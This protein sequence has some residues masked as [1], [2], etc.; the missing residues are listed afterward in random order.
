MLNE[1][2]WHKRQRIREYLLDV[3][4]ELPVGRPIPV[5]RQLCVDLGVSRPTLRS[6]VDDLVRDGRLVREHGRGVF[7][8]QAK[9]AQ[10]LGHR[11][12]TAGQA[13]GV[14]RVDG[15]WTSRTVDYRATVAG[16][17]LGRRLQISP[18]ETVLRI[19]RLRMVGGDPMCVERLHLPQAVVP[20]LTAADLETGSFYQ[21]LG[22]R[23]GIVPTAAAQTI[24][25]TVV[26]DAEAE[27]LAV[28]LHAPAL[29]FE[30]TTSDAEGRVVEYTQSLYRGDR[31]RIHTQLA[32]TVQPN[33]GR[34]LAG[35]WAAASFV[36]GADTLAVDPYWADGS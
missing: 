25:P 29:L 33:G 13:L 30:R 18:G 32:L 21:L 1:S 27:L 24:E 31:Y 22:H 19:T 34:V 14:G 10:H 36:P 28:P 2:R 8:A 12:G 15:T 20:G 35:S 9:V 17:R 7:V 3:I 23:Y 11:P 6:V 4:E 5:E 26:D 16:P